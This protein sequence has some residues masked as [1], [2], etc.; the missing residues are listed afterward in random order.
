MNVQTGFAQDVRV[1]FTGPYRHA[2][3]GALV[4]SAGSFEV[5]NPATDEVVAHAPNASR[6]Q[7]EQ[8]IAAA[9]AAQPG[10]AALSQD[11]RGAYIAAYAD[12]LDAHKQELIT[13][14]TTDRKSVV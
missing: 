11:E 4:D 12:A 7:V 10:W 6:D 3:N 13:L 14:L 1:D 5:F 8:A 2:I 9:K